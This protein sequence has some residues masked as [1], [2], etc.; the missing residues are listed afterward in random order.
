[1]DCRPRVPLQLVGEA[2]KSRFGEERSGAAEQSAE[3]LVDA[4]SDATRP[5]GISLGDGGGADRA[6]T[7]VGFKPNCLG[8]DPSICED[9]GSAA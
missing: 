8:I 2:G 3:A 9:P 1:M 4:G 6:A 7:D 5:G